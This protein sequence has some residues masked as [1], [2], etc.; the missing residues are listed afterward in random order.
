MLDPADNNILN[1]DFKDPDICL[2]VLYN[3]KYT[4]LEGLVVEFEFDRIF[5]RGFINE[6]W[7]LFDYMVLKLKNT[8]GEEQMLVF[9]ENNHSR[10]EELISELEKTGLPVR[11]V[12][13]NHE[14][15]SIFSKSKPH[16]KKK[17]FCQISEH[18]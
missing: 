5:N 4:R 16:L 10:P 7:Q 8:A 9:Q 1:M 15:G 12:E 13:Q 14:D 18:K 3:I 6:G 11:F 2:K 17:C